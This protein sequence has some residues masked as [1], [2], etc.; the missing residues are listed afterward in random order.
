MFDGECVD[1][2]LASGFWAGTDVDGMMMLMID[3]TLIALLCSALCLA[4]GL[5]ANPYTHISLG[6]AASIGCNANSSE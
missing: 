5:L 4:P 3:L 1:G 2:V 6:L